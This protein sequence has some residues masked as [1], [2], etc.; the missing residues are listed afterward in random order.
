MAHHYPIW[1]TIDGCL[2]TI[3]SVTWYCL[4]LFRS[5]FVRSFKISSTSFVGML[6]ATLKSLFSDCVFRGQSTIKPHTDWPALII[7]TILSPVI[8]PRLSPTKPQKPQVSSFDLTN[9]FV[10]HY[11]MSMYNNF[12]YVLTRSYKICI[13]KF[14]S[15]GTV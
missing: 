11:S 9:H 2:L 3:F 10:L 7:L 1:L 8:E 6:V 4:K 15:S 13:I 14:R 5:I 12:L